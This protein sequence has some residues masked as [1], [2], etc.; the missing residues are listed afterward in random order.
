MHGIKP[1]LLLTRLALDSSVMCCRPMDSIW[2]M[3]AWARIPLATA[4]LQ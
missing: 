4:A 3:Q 2:A 1:G